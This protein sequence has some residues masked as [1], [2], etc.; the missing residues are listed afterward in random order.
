[1][2]TFN[3]PLLESIMVEVSRAHRLAT[4]LLHLGG[5][6]TL[7]D[8]PTKAEDHFNLFSFARDSFRNIARLLDNGTILDVSLSELN[9]KALYIENYCALLVS[10]A[11]DRD[12]DRAAAVGL[13]YDI[14]GDFSEQLR[15]AVAGASP[16]ARWMA[17][18]SVNDWLHSKSNCHCPQAKSGG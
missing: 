12:H 1:M 18:P 7:R 15:E 4:H 14:I 17:D 3:T 2:S 11:G 8:I 16:V 6:E 10:K 9:L 5:N 13:A